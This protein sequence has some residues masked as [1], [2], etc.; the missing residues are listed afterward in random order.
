[1]SP[2]PALPCITP[3][4]SVTFKLRP[5]LHLNWCLNSAYNVAVTSLS[6]ANHALSITESIKHLLFWLL[7]YSRFTSP[8]LF[9]YVSLNLS[10]LSPSLIC[11]PFCD[12][13]PQLAVRTG[14]NISMENRQYVNREYTISPLLILPATAQ[15]CQNQTSLC[16]LN[17]T[18]T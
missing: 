13:L 18:Y 3:C 7:F 14:H 11:S 6:Q 8:I 16:D 2:T 15:T 5:N 17:I 1:M 9:T 10:S 12:I 4:S